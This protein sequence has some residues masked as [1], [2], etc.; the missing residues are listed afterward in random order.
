MDLQTALP[1]LN[2]PP[3]PYRVQA[4]EA[5]AQFRQE[6]QELAGNQS[7]IEVQT[8]VGLLLYDVA[9]RMGLSP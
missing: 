7:L 1:D 2:I 5:L 9:Q 3:H 8:P 6:W 4:V